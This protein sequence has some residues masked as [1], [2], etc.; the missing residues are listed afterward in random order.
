MACY[1]TSLSMSSINV[2]LIIRYKA[3]FRNGAQKQCMR[4]TDK[5]T[6]DFDFITFS[7]IPLTIFSIFVVIIYTYIMY[8]DLQ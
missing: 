5:S 6:A 4:G 2:M 8:T 7:F 3:P 1:K